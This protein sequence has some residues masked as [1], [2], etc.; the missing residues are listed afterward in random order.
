MARMLGRSKSLRLKISQ[1]ELHQQEGDIFAPPLTDTDAEPRTAAQSLKVAAHATKAVKRV[2]TPEQVQ[3]PRTSSGP[4]ERSRHLHENGVPVVITSD[5]RTFNFPL[6]SPKTVL[7]TAEVHEDITIGMALGSPTEV[8]RWNQ[9]THATG[10]VTRHPGAG[11]QIVYENSWTDPLDTGHDVT[12]PKISRW[13][14]LFGKRSNN[15]PQQT[16][17]YQL[18]QSAGQPRVDNHND[19]S[20]Q[21]QRQASRSDSRAAS[22]PTTSER[23][24]VRKRARAMKKAAAEEAK[25]KSEFEKQA[26]SSKPASMREEASPKPPPKDHWNNSPS[27][28]KVMVSSGSDNM[29]PRTLGGGPMLDVDIPNIEMERYSVMFGSLLRPDR[30]SSLFARRQANPEKL[31]PL[32]ELSAKTEYVDSSNGLLKPHRRATSPAPSKSPTIS[33]SLFPPPAPARDNKAPSPRAPLLHQPRPLQRSYTAP[34]ALSPSRQTFAQSS[35]AGRKSPHTATSED[36]LSPSPSTLPMTPTPS[37][38]HSFDSEETVFVVGQDANPWRPRLQEPEWEIISKPAESKSQ[39]QHAQGQAHAA[40]QRAQAS[41][42]DSA[43]HD[44]AQV[45]VGVA[46]TVS[47]SRAAGATRRPLLLKPMVVNSDQP[48]RLV[49]RKPLTPTLVELKNRKSQRVQL[50]DA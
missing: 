23:Q 8:T 16:S 40:V 19:V 41:K 29:S 6:P 30:S 21:R 15:S 25:A 1:K 45:S 4:G 50:V 10:Y 20:C 14:S 9:N 27:I 2:E 36:Q 7:Y 26:S 11:T 42:L 43:F 17:F 3:R 48:E 46:R 22:P 28:P 49:D 47:V 35:D 13:R 44:T 38:R 37:S 24:D 32:T 33:L 39:V 31:K 12:K 34:G 18:Q 5:D